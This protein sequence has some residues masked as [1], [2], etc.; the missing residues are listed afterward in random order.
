MLVWAFVVWAWQDPFTNIYTR[1]EQHRLAQNYD[2]RFDTYRPVVQS[3][4]SLAAARQELR[5]AAKRY[6]VSARRGEAIGRISVRRMGIDMVLVNGSDH[7]ALTKGPGRDVRT[8]MPGE[9]ELV[10][11][12]G[13]RT[14]YLAPFSHIDSLRQGDRVTLRMPYATFVYSVTGHRIVAANDLSV[15][16]SRGHELLALQACHPRFFATHRYIAYAKL[17]SVQMRGA[18]AGVSA[19]ALAAAAQS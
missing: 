11:V 8:A 18:P 5:V 2:K 6:R 19:T 1:W 14:T 10:Y 3:N 17:V 15:L 13:H 4:A 7:A 9:G 16:K 12:A